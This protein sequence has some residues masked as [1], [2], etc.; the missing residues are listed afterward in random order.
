MHKGIITYIRDSFKILLNNKALLYTGLIDA[1]FFMGLIYTTYRLNQ[2]TQSTRQVPFYVTGSPPPYFTATVIA[3]FIGAFILAGK[4]YM[5]RKVYEGHHNLSKGK[6]PSGVGMEEYGTGLGRFGLKILVGRVVILIATFTIV[7]L[8]VFQLLESEIPILAASAPIV[9]FLILL[10]ITL[11][12]IIMVAEDGKIVDSIS[13]SISFVKKNYIVVLALQIFSGFIAFNS[14]LHP[15][16]PLVLAERMRANQLGGNVERTLVELPAIY[17]GII[18]NLGNYSW[19]LI[20]G[21]IVVLNVIA[22]M[23]LMDL[24][25]DRRKVYE[26]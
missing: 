5:I 10:L 18:N 14:V 8:L 26:K 9:F 17:Q 22:P 16:V 24:Y 1:V 3:G 20:F 21:L 4:L 11:W 19:I 12:E 2:I 13:H 15:G 7:F 25:M 23:V 6:E